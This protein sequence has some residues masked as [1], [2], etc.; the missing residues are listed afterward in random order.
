MTNASLSPAH[1]EATASDTI[2]TAIEDNLCAYAVF[3]GAT[4][5]AE[6]HDHSDL[7]WVMS[8][9]PTLPFTGIL[10]PYPRITMLAATIRT[11]MTHFQ[12]ER[13]RPSWI[14][15]PARS[16]ADF[17]AQLA[18]HHLSQTANLPGM[19][20]KLSALQEPPIQPL[21]IT[22][23]ADPTM[24]ATWVG[25]YA[26]SNG[27]PDWIRAELMSLFSAIDYQSAQPLTLYLAWQADQPVATAAT[28]WDKGRVGLYEVATLPAFR[29]QGI[30]SRITY[31]ALN[32]ARRKDAGGEPVLMR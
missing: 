10:R 19:A 29:C 8:R 2:T 1:R 4:S 5:A 27:I 13:A 24:L 18:E 9:I 30:A 12:Q 17:I 31:Y 7:L 15:N 6:L 20:L 28:F 23:V 22:T 21:P 3:F 26:K 11:T 32:D 25:I 14:F 16:T